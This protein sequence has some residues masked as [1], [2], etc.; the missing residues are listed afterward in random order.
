MGSGSIKI[1]GTSFRV[2]YLVHSLAFFVLP[3]LGYWAN[4]YKGRVKLWYL[5]IVISV[6]LAIGT[7]FL[8]MLVPG[9]VLNPFDTL[10]NLVGLLVGVASVQIYQQ[11]IKRK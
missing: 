9:R 1:E 4:G 10:S 7:E 5:F 2:D 8:Q 11:F 3:V 6:V